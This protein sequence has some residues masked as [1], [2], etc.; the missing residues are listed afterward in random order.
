[1]VPGD[2]GGFGDDGDDGRWE[3]KGMGNSDESV[4]CVRTLVDVEGTRVAE[5]EIRSGARGASHYHSSL[6]EHCVC[7]QGK[8]DVEVG[9]GSARSLQPGD[10]VEIDPGVVHQ[11]SNSG[12]GPGRY[13]VVQ[14]GGT[15]DFVEV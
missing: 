5:F 11:I 2:I 6:S 7:L 1:M 4:R 14:H 15:Y 10:R 13:L 3:A 9:G 12:P 8:I